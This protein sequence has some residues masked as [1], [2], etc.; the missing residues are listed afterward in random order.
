MIKTEQDLVRAIVKFAKERGT[1]PRNVTR[2]AFRTGHPEGKRK[3]VSRVW[4]AASRAAWQS[5]DKTIAPVPAGFRVKGE[6]KD[7]PPIPVGFEVQ[8]VSTLV[9]TV[10]G[11]QWIKAYRGK[12]TREQT[13]ARLLANLPETVPARVGK[14]PL[15]TWQDE[16]RTT[17]L[18]SVYPMG[19]PHF[20]MLASARECG[21]AWDLEIAERINRRAI[22]DLVVRGP[23]SEVAL[24]INLGDFFHSDTP[25]GTTTKGT[26]LDV[27]GRWSKT[28]EVGMRSITHMIDCLLVHHPRV[29]VDCQIGNHDEH[30][31]IMLAIGLRAHY[32]NEP[33]I[34]VKV[35]P[36]PFHFFR[37]GN[38]LLGSTH[39][40]GCKH[41]DLPEI[42]A[43]DSP[44]WS[45]CEH[46]HW[47]IGHVHHKS[48]IQKDLRGCTV[49][50]VRTLAA[51]D[52]WHHRSG[53]RSPRD[54]QRIVYHRKFGEVSRETASAGYLESGGTLTG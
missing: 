37:F 19:D 8:G 51:R 36:N 34:D 23:R 12:E 22:E 28:L 21:E 25:H 7:Q 27:D 11:V 47:W 42:M 1:H 53:Y 13:L 44:D 20:G 24:L 29:I 54:M 32:R 31:S 49:E 6:P 5:Q 40:D 46:R 45:A 35:D 41:A 52:A 18:V 38:V 26:R 30:S 39:G 48:L 15:G 14:I 10:D 16:P 33:R 3:I 50:S 17:D 43:V 4:G 9:P 2:A